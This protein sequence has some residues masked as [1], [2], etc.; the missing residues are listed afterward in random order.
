MKFLLIGL[1]LMFPS[2]ASAAIIINEIAWMGSD[3]SANHEWIELYNTDSTSVDV[4]D[5]VLTDSMNLSIVLSG[6][7]PGGSYAVLER[8]SEDSAPGSSFLIYTGA[9]VNIGAT[10]TLKRVDDAIEDQV[11]GGENWQN[12]G[13]DNVTKETAQ[14]GSNGWVTAIPTPGVTN[15]T[16]VSQKNESTDTSQ[17]KNTSTSHSIT[18]GKNGGRAIP[19]QLPDVELGLLVQSQ[20]IGYVNQDIAF[21]TEPSGIGK[22]LINSLSYVWNFGDGNVAYGKAVHHAFSYPGTYVVTVHGSYARHEKVQRHEITILPVTMSLTK[23]SA[24]DIQ[25]HNDAPYDLDLSGYVLRGQKEFVFPE[26]SIMLSKQTITIP[27]SKIG[28]GEY[29]TALYDTE[30]KLLASLV[31]NSVQLTQ[32]TQKEPYVALQN[33]PVPRISAISTDS[34]DGSATQQDHFGFSD[35]EST[36]ILAAVAS[37]TQIAST[38]ASGEKDST[39][40]YVGLIALLSTGIFG[41]ALRPSRNHIG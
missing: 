30:K 12:I 9:L 24:G 34:Y 2:A 36:P 32:N 6:S 22:S 11:A 35:T 29:M 19:L 20:E 40:P 28:H 39:W 8:T 25:I 37:P 13:G 16:T 15:I 31:P 17:D 27:G 3:Q 4:S 21:T 7:I 33:A 18:K 41:V 5:W 10:L 23:N 1:V 38:I 26:Y 14:Y